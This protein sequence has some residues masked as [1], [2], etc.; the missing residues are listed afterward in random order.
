[1]SRN[2]SDV[3]R[4]EASLYVITIIPVIEGVDTSVVSVGPRH[5]ERH[6]ELVS[7]RKVSGIERLA[8]AGTEVEVNNQSEERDQHPRS[9]L[10]RP[11]WHTRFQL[12]EGGNDGVY[13]WCG[14][15]LRTAYLTSHF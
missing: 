12:S 8:P 7:V 4:V 13:A 15:S 1:M 10:G 9:S 11:R 6:A 3:A 2:G 5:G 14:G